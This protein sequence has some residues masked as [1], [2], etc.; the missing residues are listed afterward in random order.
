M[1][2]GGEPT[3]YGLQPGEPGSLQ[4]LADSLDEFLEAEMDFE[5]GPCVDWSEANESPEPLARVTVTMPRT[6]GPSATREQVLIRHRSD[7]ILF[8]RDL[9]EESAGLTRTVLPMPLDASASWI[10]EFWPKPHETYTLTIHPAESKGIRQGEAEQTSEGQW[11]NTEREGVPVCVQFLSPSRADFVALRERLLGE[12]IAGEA[13]AVDRERDRVAA[14]PDDQTMAALLQ[15]LADFRSRP[16]PG[17]PPLP[18]AGAGSDLAA[19]ASQMR[20][21]LA[22]M[23][24]TAQPPTSPD[25][26]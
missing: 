6:D 23:L 10:W 12:A 8:V 14:L 1:A 4:K 16:D 3:V 17:Q 26:N 15:Q 9:S 24:R 22:E 25:R 19:M 13:E 21:R 20:D 5:E 11:R 2:A 7:L 18:G